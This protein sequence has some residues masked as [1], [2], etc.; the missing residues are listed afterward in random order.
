MNL[1][2]IGPSGAGK[3]TQADRIEPK[4]NLT[5]VS[6]GD[7][8]REG[9]TEQ[10]TL[11]KMIKG[12]MDRGQLIRD[13]VVDALIKS[14]LRKRISE[15]GLLLDGFPRTEYQAEFLDELLSELGQTLDAVIYLEVSDEEI[16]RRLPG[17]ITCVRCHTP[18]HQLHK[19]F[20]VCHNCGSREVYQRSDDNPE[21]IQA[22]LKVFHR[23]VI[24]VVEFYQKTGRLIVVDGEG[25][26]DQVS[27]RVFEVIEAANHWE[28]RRA[29]RDELNRIQGRRDASPLIP[30]EKAEDSLNVVF[31][32]SP[33][34]GKGTQA[35]QL[36]KLLDLPHVSTGEL[37]RDH[38]KEK[39]TLGNLAKSFMNRGELV[40]DDV[41]E[42]MVRERLQQSNVQGGFILDGFPRNIGQAEALTDIMTNLRRRLSGVIYIN[43][44]DDEIV[45]RLSGR[46]I[47][48]N[49][50]T[51]FHVAYKPPAKKGRC[52][53]CGGN[54]Y[55][56]DDDDPDTVRARLRTYYGQTAPLVYYYRGMGVLLEVKGEG[57][58]SE[59]C[60]RI[61]SA[62]EK[63]KRQERAQTFLTTGSLF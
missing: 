55:R 2:L 24:S 42:A 39:T 19:P 4:F 18:F 41:T 16:K 26:I 3:G 53:L 28:A 63:L 43:V 1:V 58:V 7:L 56:R 52:D 29:S 51:P 57:E 13:E 32:G 50:Q 10:T 17:R 46:V 49:C 54:L 36:S 25:T 11:G 21:T 15:A 61:R 48:N 8:L 35:E 5:H 6:I 38:I 45:K 27:A 23:Q 30:R 60:E 37:F 40:P 33:G 34:S 14:R 22:R 62:L 31:L 44:S 59:V 47:C 9:A 20:T 12:Y